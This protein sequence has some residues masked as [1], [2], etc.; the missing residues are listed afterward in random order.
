[1]FTHGEVKL[2]AGKTYWRIHYFLFAG[3]NSEKTLLE[4]HS[5]IKRDDFSGHSLLHTLN[6]AAILAIPTHLLIMHSLMT[7]IIGIK[8][9][10]HENI[11][12][13]LDV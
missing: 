2:Y 4:T 6:L 10:A 12:S 11:V 3:L 13:C 9:A 1:M 8:C 7:K 5:Y